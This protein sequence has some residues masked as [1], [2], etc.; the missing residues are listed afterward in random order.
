VL[1]QPD[2]ADALRF[3]GQPRAVISHGRPVDLDRMTAL[4]A[5]GAAE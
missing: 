1:D 4:V 5:A 2:I 3:H